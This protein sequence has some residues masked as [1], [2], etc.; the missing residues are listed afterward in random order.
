MITFLEDVAPDVPAVEVSGPLTHQDYQHF[1][2][3]AEAMMA[4]GP[5]KALYV[6]DDNATEFSP[7]AFWDDQ[8]FGVK[9]WRDFRQVALVTDLWWARAAARLF[10]PVFPAQMKIF[11]KAELADAKA[12]LAA[13]A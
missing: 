2:P 8:L 3:K 10:A 7:Q 12:W 13:G 5:V 11:T 9:H 1:I 4:N 6:V